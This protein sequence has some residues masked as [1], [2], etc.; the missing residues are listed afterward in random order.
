V[1]F[2]YNEVSRR[3]V[4]YEPTFFEPEWRRRPDKKIKQGSAAPFGIEG[5][6]VC[7]RYYAAAM[8]MAKGAYDTLLNEGVAPEQAR[9]VLPQSMYTSWYVTGSLAAWARAY[10]LRKDR[11]KAQVEIADLAAQWDKIIAP[12]FP[13]A[14]ESLIN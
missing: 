12:L 6:A 1:G 9:M 4:D 14:W 10:N 11:T 7:N 8:G 2:S 5:Q 13:I 3:Y